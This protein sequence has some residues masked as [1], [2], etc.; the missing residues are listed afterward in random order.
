MTADTQGGA[1]AKQDVFQSAPDVCD[2]HKR[3]T[4]TAQQSTCQRKEV[5]S[6][7]Q[8]S[9]LCSS[10]SSRTR[11]SWRLFSFARW[12]R[13]VAQA[14]TAGQ[15]PR[16]QGSLVGILQLATFLQVSTAGT[17]YVS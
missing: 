7:R 11:P 17:T 1:D 8:Q 6:R 13:K 16:V 4:T 5:P 9:Q 2:H 3:S 15:H 10:H 14:V 12:Q